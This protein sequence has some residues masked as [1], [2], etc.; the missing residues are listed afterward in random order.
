MKEISSLEE[1]EISLKPLQP[2]ICGLIR[3]KNGAGRLVLAEEVYEEFLKKGILKENEHSFAEFEAFLKEMVDQNDDLKEIKD[4]KGISHYYSPGS[5][6]ESYAQLIV[7]RGLDPWIL[8]AEVVRENSERYPRP[9][10]IDLFGDAPFD[11]TR[12]EISACLKGMADLKEY[13]DIQQ[14]TTSVG[15]VFLYSR[16]SP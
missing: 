4:G 12:E 11:L 13:Q 10:P 15:R 6:V 8:M 7:R 5:M 2:E 16:R 3:R 9:V 1:T 14:T